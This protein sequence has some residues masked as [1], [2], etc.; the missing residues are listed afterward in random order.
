MKV[1]A[2]IRLWYY[3]METGLFAVNAS[4]K[5]NFTA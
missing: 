1:P 5:P 4:V 2:W 3:V